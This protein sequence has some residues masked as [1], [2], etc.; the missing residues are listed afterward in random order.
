MTRY[1]LTSGHYMASPE[2]PNSAE[3]IV[4]ILRRA[5]VE[6]G[7]S[8]PTYSLRQQRE[9]LCAAQTDTLQLCVESW[10]CNRSH[11]RWAVVETDVRSEQVHPGVPGGQASSGVH[12]LK[13]AY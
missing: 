2:L 11:R 7:I 1:T 12:G 5:D 9:W 8:E 6:S 10:L 3:P 13:R 4:A